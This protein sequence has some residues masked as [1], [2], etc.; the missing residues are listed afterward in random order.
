MLHWWTGHMEVC[1]GGSSMRDT[2]ASQN[3]IGKWRQREVK[4]NSNPH[5]LLSHQRY[6]D[7]QN[8]T[9]GQRHA[10][11]HTPSDFC[12]YLILQFIFWNPRLV[13]HLPTPPA[14][15]IHVRLSRHQTHNIL[16]IEMVVLAE[17][18]QLCRS[19]VS[20]PNPSHFSGRLAWH[21]WWWNWEGT[22]W[23]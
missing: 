16:Q 22:V 11:E 15:L 20:T 19:I 14:T 2:F 12:L 9:P 13:S 5:P 18:E 1:Y 8:C 23:R 7:D 17:R 3:E 4:T 21:S 6:S 10:E